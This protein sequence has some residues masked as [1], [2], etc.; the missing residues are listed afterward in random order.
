MKV[1]ILH[2]IEQRYY[3]VQGG[4]GCWVAHAHNIISFVVTRKKQRRETMDVK[5]VLAP[6]ARRGIV[7]AHRRLNLV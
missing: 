6:Q 2:V 3:P 4:E 7:A 1:L 5:V